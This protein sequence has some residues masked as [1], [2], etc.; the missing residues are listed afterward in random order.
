MSENQDTPQWMVTAACSRNL[1]VE[2]R[3]NISGDA[4]VV[5]HGRFLGKKDD[6]FQLELTS[7]DLETAGVKVGTHY[8]AFFVASDE[9]F[10]FGGEFIET[11]EDAP[12]E[13][14][15]SR[16]VVSRGEVKPV[17]RRDAY[18]TDFAGILD[19]EVRLLSIN[20]DTPL[21]GPSEN[22]LAQGKIEDASVLGLGVV[23][24]GHVGKGH[25]PDTQ[26]YAAFTASG[27]PTPFLMFTVLRYVREFSVTF[28]EGENE[29][30]EDKTIL[31]F[32]LVNWPNQVDF[33]KEM[34]RFERIVNHVQR[35]R[36]KKMA[37]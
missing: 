23:L 35:E 17:Q 22:V 14:D 12:S 2:L 15:L 27:D 4:P 29:V 30:V 11:G 26:M 8:V 9:A 36:R 13:N 24:E 20:A 10:T 5:I 7:A 31:G 6:T 28:Y 33:G 19:V 1:P 18:R 3:F 16:T 25:E 34:V 32:E 21:E 37:A